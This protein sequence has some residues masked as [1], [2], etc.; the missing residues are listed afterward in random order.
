MI[1]LIQ[2]KEIISLTVEDDGI[3]FSP[4]DDNASGIGIRNMKNR[5]ELWNGDFML[6]SKV[7]EG[8]TVSVRFPLLAYDTTLDQT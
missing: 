6:E 1:E 3:G 4:E 5:T 8:T 7:S 2:H